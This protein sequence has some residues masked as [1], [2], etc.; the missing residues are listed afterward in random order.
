MNITLQKK[1]FYYE[2]DFSDFKAKIIFKDSCIEN[3]ETKNKFLLSE[4][5]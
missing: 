1:I 5:N 4:N 3:L 2:K